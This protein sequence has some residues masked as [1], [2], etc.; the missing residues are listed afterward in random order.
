MDNQKN[1]LISVFNK[2]G[3]SAFAEVLNKSGYRIIATEG[4]GKELAKNN[5]PFTSAEQLS[6]NPSGLEE[7]IKTISF[8]IEAGI[9][10]DRLNQRQVERTE[11][12]GISKIDIVVCNLLDFGVIKE[13][14]DFNVKNID[15][16]GPLM[17]R[18]AAANFRNVLIVV[19]PKDY[20]RVSKAISENKITDEFRQKLAIK[21][22][23]YTQSYDSKIVEYLKKNTIK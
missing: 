6:R 9:L 19:D 15:V 18:A 20:K 8:N 13:T 17:I 22:F 10:F 4:T 14:A 1:V 3:I 21:A 5:I 23:A 16:G 11:K 7:C 2:N 12:L